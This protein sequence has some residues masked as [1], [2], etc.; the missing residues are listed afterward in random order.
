MKYDLQTLRRQ[1]SGKWCTLDVETTGFAIGR[2]K[3]VQVAVAS[4]RGTRQVDVRRQMDMLQSK[5]KVCDTYKLA[6]QVVPGRGKGLHSLG[7]LAKRF[8]VELPGRLHRADADAKVNGQVFL[9]LLDYEDPQLNMLE[10][11]PTRKKRSDYHG[12]DR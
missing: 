2:D 4:F 9:A 3:I 12:W 5:L 7:A 1:S 8:G 10:R 11:G 6:K